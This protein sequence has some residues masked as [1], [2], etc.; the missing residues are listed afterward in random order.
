MWSS[1]RLLPSNMERWEGRRWVGR[2]LEK[3]GGRRCMLCVCM[4]PC[5]C[6]HACVTETEIEREREEMRELE[7]SVWS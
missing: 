6:A 5:V 3:I 7:G 4:V 1:S 2:A